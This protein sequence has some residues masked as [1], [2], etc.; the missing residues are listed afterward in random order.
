[1]LGVSLN[2]Q[3]ARIA[4]LAGATERGEATVVKKK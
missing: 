4:G 2:R 1:V 3:A